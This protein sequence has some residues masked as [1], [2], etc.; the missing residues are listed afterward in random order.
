MLFPDDFSA[1]PEEAD[2]GANF[3]DAVKIAVALWREHLE[4]TN[5][6]RREIGELESHMAAQERDSNVM[7]P[8]KW[9]Q[10][11]LGRFLTD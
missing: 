1:Y 3:D 4:E 10:R 5:K 2:V 7:R 8:T 6:L 11:L 9:L